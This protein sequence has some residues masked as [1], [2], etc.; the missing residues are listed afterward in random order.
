MCG[1]NASALFKYRCISH[2]SLEGRYL[3]ALNQVAYNIMG[4]LISVEGL[5]L[6]LYA[7]NCLERLFV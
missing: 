6:K 7:F 5:S 2:L 1:N 3:S 4:L